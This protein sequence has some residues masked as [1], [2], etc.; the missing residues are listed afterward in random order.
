MKKLYKI[1]FILV[2]SQLLFA[3]AKL[4][5]F[6]AEPQND[7]VRLEWQSSSEYDIKQYI[8]LRK[9]VSGSWSE[10]AS[11][12]P[13]GDGYYSFDDRSVFKSTNSVYTYKIKIID[14]S[15]TIGNSG[16]V[17]V[18]LKISGVKRTWGSI[19]AMFR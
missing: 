3:G 17:N 6:R 18:S 11:I 14:N 9:T 19:K 8:V 15:G 7:C 13:K 4:V 2:L 5:S 1:L 12:A 16:D 10:I